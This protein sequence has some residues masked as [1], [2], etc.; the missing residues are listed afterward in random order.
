[1]MSASMP[2]TGGFGFTSAGMPLAPL[3]A[4]PAV[5]GGVACAAVGDDRVYVGT[6]DGALVCCHAAPASATPGAC[7]AAGEIEWR[8]GRRLPLGI[9]R[10]RVEQLELVPTFGMLLVLAD[11]AVGVHDA[12]TLERRGTL[13]QSKGAGAFCVSPAASGAA[14]CRVCVALRRGKPLRLVLYELGALPAPSAA[15]A[16]AGM[17]SAIAPMRAMPGWAPFKTLLTPEP[18]LALAWGAEQI[19]VGYAAEYALVHDASGEV[20]EL[21]GNEPPAPPLILAL[22]ARAGQASADGHEELLIVTGAVG[23][24]VDL[25]HA[26]AAARSPIAWDDAPR[27]LAHVGPFILALLPASID[28]H[29]L[30]DASMPHARVQRLP[31][32]PRAHGAVSY[33]HL[34]LPTK[35]I[36]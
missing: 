5:I 1:M 12:E 10:R 29:L 22:G 16:P 19:C 26:T 27:A 17:L 15:A 30:G 34:T 3:G 31:P 25:A 4:L 8:L 35:R 13:E 2:P 36:V 7:A 32:P 20:V 6:T 21:L 33:T 24:F 9:G 14:A 28:V 18:P 11:G 23:T